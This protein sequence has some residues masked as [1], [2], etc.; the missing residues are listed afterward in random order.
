MQ[1]LA[2]GL[3]LEPL[4]IHTVHSAPQKGLLT[5]VFGTKMHLIGIASTSN[6][7]SNTVV[8]SSGSLHFTIS[9]L[10]VF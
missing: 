8:P 5:T 7:N 2:R 1:Y 4:M 9:Y 10:S 3:N 6:N